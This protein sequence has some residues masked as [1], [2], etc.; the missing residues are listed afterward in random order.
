[1]ISASPAAKTILEQ[2]NTLTINLGCTLEYNMNSLVDNITMSGAQINRLDAA[3][4]AYQPFKKL[5]PIDS[6]IKA[7]RPVKAGIKY[8]IVGDI[9]TSTYRNPKSIDYPLNFRTY[10]PGVETQYKY[11]LSDKNTGL[12]VTA[13]YP[14]TILTNKIVARFELSHST[15]PTWAIYNGATQIASGTSSDIKTFGNQDA[16]TLTVYYNGTSWST[17]EPTSIPAPVNMTSLRITTG[18]VSDK[19]IGLIE[20]SPRWVVDISD[21]VTNLSVSKDASSSADDILPVGYVSANSLQMS[22]VSYE[23]TRQVISFDKTMNFDSTKVYLYKMVQAAPYFKIYH[24]GGTLSDS[25]GSY[26]KIKQGVFYLDSWASGE[27]G[28][29]SVNALD[30]AKILQETIC[31]GLVCTGYA[32]TAIIRTLLDNI[33]FTNYNFNLNA[34]DTSIFSPRFWWTED[35]K[36]VWESIQQLC[37]DSQ[38]VATFDENNILQFYTRENIFNYSGAVDWSFRYSA[39][40]S[41]LPNIVAL[42]KQDLSSANQVK[43]IWNSVTTNEYFGSAQPL[44]KSSST[45]MLALSLEENLLSTAGAGSYIKLKGVVTDES[46]SN[47]SLNSYSGFLAIGSEI[48]EYDAIQYDYVDLVDGIKKQADITT[49]L[50][51]LK[52]LGLS[53][54]GSANFQPNGKYRIKTRGAYNTTPEN[55]YATA[56]ATINAWSGYDVVWV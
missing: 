3:G 9:G 39:N 14:K 55:H 36:T 35:N 10:Y 30:G 6:I 44:W 34:S 27:F 52:Y 13:T 33:G 54:A 8:A 28:D 42:D 5:F 51:A 37:R 40:G 47:I 25:G 20:L 2:D 56:Q 7:V 4:N 32:T 31:P 43:V 49:Q 41:N 53:A 26:E 16:G 17:T 12:D 22:L 1:M 29:I 15:P 21:R 46:Q 23:D 24:S 48:I 19:Y 38:M 18:S 45:Y 11:Y 50:D